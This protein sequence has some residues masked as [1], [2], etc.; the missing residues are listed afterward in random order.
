[1][2]HLDSF[3]SLPASPATIYERKR[4][5]RVDQ[6]RPP[7]TTHNDKITDFS[8]PPTISPSFSPPFLD[9]MYH[10]YN[11]ESYG[12]SYRPWLSVYAPSRLERPER[13]PSGILHPVSP[14]WLGARF[15]SRLQYAVEGIDSLVRP[16]DTSKP[17]IDPSYITN[18]RA[19]RL[20]HPSLAS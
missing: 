11:M 5:P 3:G 19:R 12:T 1:M 10:D 2:D 15:S 6:E 9:D 14:D 16:V 4:G 18:A 17:A 7:R 20:K 13:R 8:S